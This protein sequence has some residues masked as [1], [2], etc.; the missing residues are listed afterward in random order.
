[1]PGTSTGQIQGRIHPTDF[2][3][4]FDQ[5]NDYSFDATKTTFAN[6]NQVTLYENGMLAWGTPP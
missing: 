1:M 3:Y 5:S 6:W 4:T 2:L